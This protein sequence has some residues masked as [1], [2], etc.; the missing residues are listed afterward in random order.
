MLHLVVYFIYIVLKGFDILKVNAL[1]YERCSLEFVT[2]NMGKAIDKI[3]SAKSCDEVLQ[4]R[5]EY[6]EVMTEFSTAYALSNCRYTLNTRD[7][8]YLGEKDYYDEIA[9]QAEECSV[10][11]CKAMLSSPFRKELEEKLSP[12]LFRSFEVKIKSMSPEIIPEMQEENRL[13]T[14]YSSFMSELTFEFDGEKMPLSV[15]RKHLTADDRN[16]RKRAYEALGRRLEEV[17]STL[18]SIFDKLVRV[19]D[20]MAKKMGYKNFVELG[21]YRMERLDYTKEMIEG[22]RKNI[23]SDIVPTV[24]KIKEQIAKKHGIDRFMLYDDS[25]TVLGKT[26]KPACDAEGIFAAARDMYTQMSDKTAAFFDMML[27][28][29]AFDVFSREGKW[30][31]GYCTSFEKYKQPFI[32]A[33]FNGT[34]ADVDVMTHEAGHA[35]ADFM[36]ASNELKELGIGGMETAEC[37]SM[38]MEF[39]AWRYMD[40]FFKE[41]APQYKYKHCIDALSFL[42]YGTMVDLF[43]HIVY[44]NP[45]LTPAQRKEEWKKLEEAYRPWLSIDG[46]PYIEQGTRWQYQMHIYESPFYYID[47]C[48]AQTIA[49]QFLILMQTDYDDAF[50]RYF[51]FL[52]HGGE[53]TFTQLVAEAGLK[54]PFAEGALSDLAHKIPELIEKLSN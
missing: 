29:E 43:Q 28:N 6:L 45:E 4:A 48:L 1:P 36:T 8:F 40:K 50:A 49:F 15:L 23:L 51:K 54:S 26:P 35:F 17:S 18:D 46:I 37:H 20:K 47:Y 44:E 41:K 38:S 21:Y 16:V 30:G 13:V 34:A 12:V 14:E 27:E 52:C 7:E 22:F 53:L 11:Y 19:R 2:T 25:V 5:K 32:L 10:L 9:P 3:K 42:P 24:C 33:N 31:G 39:F